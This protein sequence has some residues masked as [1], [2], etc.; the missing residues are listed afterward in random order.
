M[1]IPT[2]SLN[3]CIYIQTIDPKFDELEQK[4]MSLG[5]LVQNLLRDI[6]RWQDQL[7]VQWNVESSIDE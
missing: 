1:S 5:T 4:V 3:T 7:Q 2:P 6:A